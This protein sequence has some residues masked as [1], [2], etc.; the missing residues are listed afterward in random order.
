[1][2]VC[3]KLQQLLQYLAG[4]INLIQNPIYFE[5]VAIC[6]LFA[7]M[8]LSCQ[9]VCHCNQS[10]VLQQ[11]FKFQFVRKKEINKEML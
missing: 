6:S 7:N 10:R 4:F 3:A 8:F 11:V 1:M 5:Q 2:Y 9:I